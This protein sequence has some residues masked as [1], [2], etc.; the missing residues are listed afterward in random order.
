MPALQ[1]ADLRR[2]DWRFLLP[3]P[4]SGPL[5]RLA[6]LGATLTQV[7][8][9]RELKV[10]DEIVTSLPTEGYLDALVVLHPVRLQ[11]RQ[12]AHVLRPGG[13]C[14]WELARVTP[15]GIGFSLRLA[16]RLRM[17]GLALNGLY[18]AAPDFARRRRYIP[19]DAPAALRWYLRTSYI[20]AG[21]V[22][23]L[24]ALGARALVEVLPGAVALMA[25]YIAFTAIA[26]EDRPRPPA[27]LHRSELPPAICT[28]E[29]RVAL[30]TSG[31]DV[32]SRLVLL[33]FASGKLQ[34]EVALKIAPLPAF[35]AQTA[36]EQL[37]IAR[38]R[39]LVSASFVTT[40]PRP[41]GLY[42]CG[43]VSVS[44]ESYA[45]GR[46]IAVSSANWPV[47]TTRA[48]SDLRCA[49]AW[50]RAFHQQTMASC[51]P[52]DQAA[53]N[54]W[55]E[56]PLSA[57]ATSYHVTPQ[58]A[59]LFAA[60]RRRAQALVGAPFPLVGQ[61]NDYGPWNI[62]RD[63]HTL[64]VIDWEYGRGWQQDD[65]GPALLDLLYFVTYWV[66]IVRRLNRPEYEPGGL[67]SFLINPDW[68][69]QMVRE[70]QTI[71][72]GYMRELGLDPRFRPLLLT[73]LWVGRALH[74]VERWR[75][76]GQSCINQGGEN[77][78]LIYLNTLACHRERLFASP[79]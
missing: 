20:A 2:L 14:Y 67:Y 65:I 74:Q 66:H 42:H 70:V 39:S 27:V 34:P 50:I 78:Y 31:H 13:V 62:Y 21:P 46:P 40:I 33:P 29:T 60:V 51:E 68:R 47:S 32:G 12:A 59:D 28:P 76:T 35:N 63:E 15:R 6:V 7:E 52:L 18:W 49:A 73:L 44:I 5:R 57:F 37:R 17:A 24:L 8:L 54:E 10:A 45:S 19:L 64:M 72:A 48:V 25:P 58:L 61:H 71:L 22:Q 43:E 30:I 26:G 11:F 77:R 1:S 9:L 55:I 36:K 4:A 56:R 41:L 23:R 69:D 53:I 38:V 16:Q 79:D 75:I 3:A